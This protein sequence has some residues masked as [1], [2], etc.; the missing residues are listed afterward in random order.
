M[1]SGDA[2]QTPAHSAPGV[3]SKLHS[4]DKACLYRTE[5]PETVYASPPPALS[6]SHVQSAL[7][8]HVQSFTQRPT[9]TVAGDRVMKVPNLWGMNQKEDLEERFYRRF[10]LFRFNST[11]VQAASYLVS[12]Q[13]IP[14]FPFM[15]TF[16]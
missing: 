8:A 6:R 14:T 16:L 15:E 4:I 5:C 11:L 3:Y 13:L 2:L 10:L 12:G 1:G 7:R 9:S